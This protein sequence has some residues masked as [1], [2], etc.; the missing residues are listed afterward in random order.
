MFLNVCLSKF[1]LRQTA[2]NFAPYAD[3]TR[4][5]LT[6]RLQKVHISHNKRLSI[7]T[8]GHAWSTDA[9]AGCRCSPL[10]FL[11]YL[12]RLLSSLLLLFSSSLLSVTL[13][14]QVSLWRDHVTGPSPWRHS[15]NTV[16]GGVTCS[17]TAPEEAVGWYTFSNRQITFTQVLFSGTCGTCT[18]CTS[19]PLHLRGEYFTF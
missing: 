3:V 15:D 8:W 9:I 14:Q 2:V 4:V 19:V 7:D 10:V 12:A 16:G 6:S 18:S 11:A 17:K 5:L 13:N 1:R